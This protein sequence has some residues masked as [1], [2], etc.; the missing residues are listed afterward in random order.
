MII[1]RAGLELIPRRNRCVFGEVSK[2]IVSYDNRSAANWR[3]R[4]YWKERSQ[5]RECLRCKR[6]GNEYE[7]CCTF[8]VLGL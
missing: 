8:H 2:Q 7:Y 1:T 3:L 6:K 4:L 5:D